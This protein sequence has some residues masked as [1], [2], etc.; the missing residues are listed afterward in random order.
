MCE[1]RLIGVKLH[2]VRD[3]DDRSG[4]HL[5]SSG[6]HCDWISAVQV[7]L[8]SLSDMSALEKEIAAFVSFGELH[9]KRIFRQPVPVCLEKCLQLFSVAS[10]SFPVN[11]S[12]QL[13]HIWGEVSL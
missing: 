2:E 13:L 7:C 9:E 5:H 10:C 12:L 11:D 3:E 4:L 1:H 6:Q 8:L